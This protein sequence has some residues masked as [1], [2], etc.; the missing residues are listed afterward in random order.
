MQ[1]AVPDNSYQR[2]CAV[3]RS[4]LEK[5]GAEKVSICRIAD[6]VGISATA[7]HHYF[8]NREALLSTVVEEELLNLATYMTTLAEDYSSFTE[9]VLQY[10]PALELNL[11]RKR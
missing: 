1:Q 8:P 10:Q 5:E 3:S 2:I 7:I 4:I 11:T 6:Q 9:R